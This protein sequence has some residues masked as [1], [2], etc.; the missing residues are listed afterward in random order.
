MLLS[1]GSKSK[2]AIEKLDVERLTYEEK[3]K[4]R[5]IRRIDEEVQLLKERRRDYEGE[6]AQ[7]RQ[8]LGK[9]QDEY[10]TKREETLER[11]KQAQ[12]DRN[13][14]GEE[15]TDLIAVAKEF[16]E[17]R[18]R[19]RTETEKLEAQR[20]EVVK[21]IE[22]KRQQSRPGT[23]QSSHE[24][25]PVNLSVTDA[26]WRSFQRMKD[27][28]LRDRSELK[29]YAQI[30]SDVVSQLRPDALPFGQGD[31]GVADDQGHTLKE[32]PVRRNS[33]VHALEDLDKFLAGTQE[34][35]SLARQRMGPPPVVRLPN[36]FKSQ[37]SPKK[38]PTLPSP[39]PNP[40]NTLSPH[41]Q[42]PSP[43]GPESSQKVKSA[44][45][46]EALAASMNKASARP[47]HT[48]PLTKQPHT[49]TQANQNH[50][51]TQAKTLLEEIAELKAVYSQSADKDP[52]LLAEI[53]N[54]EKEAMGVAAGP[55]GS[56]ASSEHHGAAPGA[57]NMMMYPPR[58]H[59]QQP[60]GAAMPLYNPYTGQ[61]MMP[62][63]PPPYGAHHP[64]MPHPQ[65]PPYMPGQPPYMPQMPPGVG[66]YQGLPMGMYPDMQS[67]AAQGNNPALSSV[68]ERLRQAEEEE[69]KIRAEEEASKFI[70]LEK[71]TQALQKELQKLTGA[72][73]G[74]ATSGDPES[75]PWDDVLLDKVEK[76]K[77]LDPKSSLY[78]FEMT[79]LNDLNRLKREAEKMEEMARV[80][81]LRR[82]VDAA[83]REMEREAWAEEQKR[84]LLEARYR[85]Q[86]A[87]DQPMGSIDEAGGEYIPERGF[88]VYFDY[89]L[90]LSE[91]VGK[92]QLAYAFYNDAVAHTG[93]K[94]MPAE[95]TEVDHGNPP[96]KRCVFALQRQ[97]V[98]VSP[99]GSMRMIVEA[100]EVSPDTGKT[101]SIGWTV[102]YLFT[103][104]RALFSGLWRYPLF[105]PPVQPG[106][107]LTA[108][109]DYPKVV[110]M[111]LFLRVV[112]AA[113]TES[114]ERFPVDPGRTIAK[115]QIP[116][117]ST[118]EGGESPSPTQPPL[119]QQPSQTR[120]P[121]QGR[122]GGS[123]TSL[124]RRDDDN[125]PPPVRRQ[126]SSRSLSHSSPSPS[127]APRAPHSLMKGLR[128]VDEG[129]SVNAVGILLE[130]VSS[131]ASGLGG[132]G[133]DGSTP[134]ARRMTARGGR[135]AGLAGE[136]LHVRISV[137]AG[138]TVFVSGHGEKQQWQ[139]ESIIYNGSLGQATFDT[140]VVFTG[141]ESSDGGGMDAGA[142]VGVSRTTP[143]PSPS[144]FG[145]SSR[146]L[147]RSPAPTA[148]T[149]RLSGLRDRAPR[150]S[151]SVVLEV[152]STTGLVGWTYVELNDDEEETIWQNYRK[153]LLQGPVAMPAGSAVSTVTS[154]YVSFSMFEPGTD[155]AQSASSPTNDRPAKGS[156]PTVADLPKEVFVQSKQEDPPG[157]IF[158]QQESG[159]DLYIDAAKFL[160]DNVTVTAIN[161]K[162]L[163]R[164]FDAIR[165]GMRQAMKPSSLIGDPVFDM[166]LEFRETKFDPTATLLIELT[167]L[168]SSS[169]KR[170]VVGFAVLNLFCESPGGKGRKQP[171]DSTVREF[172][173]NAGLFQLPLHSRG[174]L[175]GQPFSVGSLVDA[176]R[177]PGASVLV[178]LYEAVRSDDG[179]RVLSLDDVHEDEWVE[180]G[181]MKP[182]PS[183]SSGAYDTSLCTPGVKDVE[184]LRT[185]SQRPKLGVKDVMSSLIRLRGTDE[186][187][188]TDPEETQEWILSV[189]EKESMV[190]EES[191]D[192]QHQCVY[193][194]TAGFKFAVEG[195]RNLPKAV[196][197][198]AVF[199]LS[200]P[201][202]YFQDKSVKMDI[203]RTH[204]FNFA[205]GLKCPKWPEDLCS[206]RNKAFDSMLCV[207]V[208]ILSLDIKKARAEVL[209]FAA[210][211][212]FTK[213]SVP[214]RAF[215][216]SGS[217]QLPLY[218]GEPPKSLLAEFESSEVDSVLR[219]ATEEKRLKLLEPASVF[220][221][222]C[223]DRLTGVFEVA[224]ATEYDSD[225]IDGFKNAFKYENVQSSKPYQS[226][227]AAGKTE[228][229]VAKE[230]NE[231]IKEASGIS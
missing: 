91:R 55:P 127:R 61:P 70:A 105:K 213:D 194:P 165:E 9:K 87:Q 174:P 126:D 187:A 152:F 72:I 44:R 74:E 104:T 138:A 225:V 156:L 171:V 17:R 103:S 111:E 60:F 2:K 5:E 130:S 206:F 13:P 180:L 30:Q 146:R 63:Y 207:V 12:H 47:A 98:K 205:S 131:A 136:E 158:N 116:S 71:Q 14:E 28:L 117:E 198:F 51:P 229:Q 58:N 121:L 107:H 23:S 223:D 224:G 57:A 66:G 140:R 137:Y 215:V 97:F 26:D 220:V 203:D 204:R 4:L 231:T 38:R 84:Q 75:K 39:N 94:T 40:S 114:H 221:R 150:P 35:P 32:I 191:L 169:A 110:G 190:N 218:R 227:L 173:L 201:G 106:N 92:V 208:E 214:G 115:Y 53:E 162:I 143:S 11:L 151:M 219:R 197:S 95:G 45:R 178:R 183:Y 177:V 31:S 52:A 222:I 128:T 175:P 41:L 163:T 124:P 34:R 36:S 78:G 1:R 42:P 189:L 3:A 101:R 118:L 67:A 186:A 49:P 109:A 21:T 113:A 160:P 96:N 43:P 149:A 212:V 192:W 33:A 164:D 100:Q 81:K 185:R 134:T 85:K 153:P 159:F 161:V 93:V 37:S 148:R 89:I 54:L 144:R 112:N 211:N 27:A 20:K 217:Y 123:A 48:P 157:E 145:T 184:I 22:K 19:I 202:T 68:E 59:Y 56:T 64:Q 199:G 80:E 76:M 24:D 125:H 50:P 79:H 182:A 10:K 6:A 200:P 168:E 228:S 8:E 46:S 62:P 147:L 102:V 86:I 25:G 133:M 73:R 108:M 210:L 216:R 77:Q 16:G 90:G 170:Q 88:V 181:V 226:L 193:D 196:P 69:R 142:G 132:T 122:E 7:V 154:V 166:R 135:L 195:A 141:L 65:H 179:V 29:R 172:G 18:S 155:P 82:D 188:P 99:V 209:G 230:L 167:T 120:L 139:S 15:N 176:P 129:R 83:K 119:R